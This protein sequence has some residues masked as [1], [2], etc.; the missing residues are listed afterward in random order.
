MTEWLLRVRAADQEPL[1]GGVT[2]TEESPSHAH[3]Y[4][5]EAAAAAVHALTDG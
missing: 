2:L 1:S 4:A 5:K 3:G